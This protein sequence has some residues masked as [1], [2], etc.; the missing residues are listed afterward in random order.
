MTEPAHEQLLGYL[1]GALDD[2][3][4]VEIEKFLDGD[5]D[6]RRELAILNRSLAPL[7]AVRRE[8]SPPAGLASRTCAFVAESALATSTLATKEAATEEAEDAATAPLLETSVA[9]AASA[10]PAEQPAMM[11][12]VDSPCGSTGR[13]R[14]QDSVVAAG[15]MVAAC[16]LLFPAIIDSREHARIMECQNNLHEIGTALTSYSDNNNGY[17]PKVPVKGNLAAAGIYAP[18]LINSGYLPNVRQVICPGSDLADD[19][20]F[21]IPTID[22][23]QSASSPGALSAMKDRMGGSYGYSLGHIKDGR[24][25]DTKNL[26]RE[27]FALMADSPSHAV[28]SHQSRNHGGNGQNVLYEDGHVKFLPTTKP[29][30]LPDDVFINDDGL[31]AAGVHA[32]DSVI[33]SSQATPIFNAVD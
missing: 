23:L 7:D 14:W 4:Q 9:A 30:G 20:S 31:V 19:N 25:H 26:H 12:S 32:D 22:D 2:N 24:Y 10:K 8:F 1:L 3:E 15:I 18:R 29:L 6:L 27:N 13:G 17:F 11:K 16:G 28:P 5:A 33:G 21:S